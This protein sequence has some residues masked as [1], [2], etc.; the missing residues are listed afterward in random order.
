MSNYDVQYIREQ[1]PSIK[2][3]LAGLPVAYLDGPGGTQVPKRVIDKITE[4][5]IETNA[6]EGGA[7][8]T[9]VKTDKIM[10]EARIICSEFLGCKAHEV[11]FGSSSTTNSF[12]LAFA[13]MKDILPGDE[14][15]V[16]DLDHLCNRSP[17]IQLQDA[18]AII[19][20]VRVNVEEMKLDFDDYKSKLSPRTRLVALNY[21]SN[22]VGTITDV[23]KYIELAHEVG[24]ITVVDAV[25]YAAHKPID[26]KEINTDILICSPYKFFGPHL[27]VVYIR[28]SLFDKLKTIK[29]DADDLLEVPHKFQTGTP[30]FE[31]IYGTA[32]AIKFIAD[33]GEMFDHDGD[34]KSESQLTLREKIITGMNIFDEYEERLAFYLRSQLYKMP[35]IKIYGPQE[36]SER[37]STV[38]FTIDKIN[39]DIVAK[40]L[41]SKGIYAWAGHFYAKTLVNEV[42]NL[43]KD[44]GLIRV[45]VSPYNTMQEIDRLLEEV[46]ILT[47]VPLP[48]A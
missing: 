23:K 9:S 34:K 37:T 47:A 14:I 43:Q 10:E 18:G 5:L 39:S 26:V 7:F 33:A 4:Y 44:G 15:I 20:S 45:G 29:V 36:G 1:F 40:H 46:S 3:K 42:L 21:A 19:K 22:A 28:D 27:G 24:A 30:C 35:K 12:M 11:A 25:H 16:T 41:G 17:W 13:L 38:S 48:G 2:K 31:N 8:E 32:E 6:N